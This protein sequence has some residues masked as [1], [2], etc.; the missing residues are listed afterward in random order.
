[1]F[2]SPS[3]KVSVGELVDKF[4]ILEI[5]LEHLDED[6]DSYKYDQVF[7]EYHYL[8]DKVKKL[9]LGMGA[10]ANLKRVNQA[11]WNLEDKIRELH[12][13]GDF[14]EEFVQTAR[15]IYIQNDRRYRLKSQINNITGSK[16]NEQKVLP[17]YVV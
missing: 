8:K 6:E 12:S 13:D 2:R 9:K 5:K 11:I 17:D 14:G 7:L 10:I 15:A 16:F 3:I 1:M 4:T